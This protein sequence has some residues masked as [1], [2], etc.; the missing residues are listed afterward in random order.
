MVPS[1]LIMHFMGS[2]TKLKRVLKDNFQTYKNVQYLFAYAF[3]GYN[4]VHDY[5]LN[6]LN[7]YRISN[8]SEVDNRDRKR[9]ACHNAC[10]AA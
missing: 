6:L 7:P 5:L 9:N 8:E 1:D 2:E 10:F 3:S 4:P